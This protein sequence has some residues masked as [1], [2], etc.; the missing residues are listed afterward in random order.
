M[1][2]NCILALIWLVCLT[3]M[4]AQQ[5]KDK[6]ASLR[7]SKTIVSVSSVPETD[8]YAIQIIA[9]KYPAGEPSFFN[10]IEQAREFSC[11]DGYV[12]YTVG[13]FPTYA[14]A[15]NELVYY[16]DLGYVE[17]FVVNT[18]KYQLKNKIK[19]GFKPDP[20]KRYTIQLSAFRF[21]V[22]LSHFKGVEDVKE[23]YLK[24]KIYRYTVGSYSYKDAVA[25]LANIKA[26]GY[27]DAYVAEL[28]A[29]LPYQIE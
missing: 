22:Y 15:K 13:T 9:L 5:R 19:R 24:D 12:R 2:R 14:K 28:D 23:F 16:K 26:I 11:A 6:L 18:A 27:K 4:Q 10:N 7:T 3:G 8:D 20:N 29:Y 1:K 17:A 21:P 25:Q